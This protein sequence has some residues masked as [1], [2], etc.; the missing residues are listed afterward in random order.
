[1][2]GNADSI[3][4]PDGNKTVTVGDGLPGASAAAST[5][6]PFESNGYTNADAL[7]SA[8][9]EHLADVVADRLAAKTSAALPIGI[10]PNEAPG[11]IALSISEAADQLGVSEDHFR[12]HVLSDLRIV[13]SGRLRLVPVRELEDWLD[14]SAARALSDESTGA[15]TG[16]RTTRAR[17]GKP[18]TGSTAQGKAPCAPDL[19]AA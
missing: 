11:K 3:A 16:A 19:R 6:E 1:M 4:R 5:H 13:R 17:T 12:R 18:D 8:L 10:K 15:R 9:V 2:N 7:L 14:R